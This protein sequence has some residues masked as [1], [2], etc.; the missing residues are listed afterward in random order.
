MYVNTC[1]IDTDLN[2]VYLQ[3][4]FLELEAVGD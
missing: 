1:D 2:L 4:T 3:H